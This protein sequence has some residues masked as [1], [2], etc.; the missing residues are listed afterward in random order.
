MRKIKSISDLESWRKQIVAKQK[1]YKTVISVCG[2]TGCQAYGVQKVKGASKMRKKGIG[3]KV[4]LKYTGCRGF[5]E[6]GPL[7]TIHPQGIFY[8]RVKEKDVPLIISETIQ[9]GKDVEHLLYEDPADPKK[10]HSPRRTFLFI[11]PRST[12]P[13][14][15]MTSSSPRRLKIMWHWGLS[16]LA[17]A[18][19]QMN[20]QE[21]IDEIKASGLR[22]RGGAGFPTGRKWENCRQA[23]G[24]AQVCHLQLR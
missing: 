22:G 10:D 17:K 4:G 7:V 23:S 1:K 2:G 21:I 19:F 9:K 14:G 16:S 8:Q 6:R 12:G 18:L 24:D 20:P 13:A 3:E 15:I 5:C 11:E